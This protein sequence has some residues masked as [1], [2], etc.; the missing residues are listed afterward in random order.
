M[1]KLKRNNM[2]QKILFAV[3][4]V[5]LTGFTTQVSAQYNNGNEYKTNQQK[6]I[7]NGVRNG[8]LTR[9]EARHLRMR[10]AK[11][12]HDRQMAMR[13]G[14]IT[15]REMRQLRKAEKRNNVAIYNNKHNRN[16]RY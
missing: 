5:A 16:K 1:N 15:R 4:I 13:D 9:S 10:E 6:R 11:L 8:E 14:K 7:H 2:K 12:R 3:L